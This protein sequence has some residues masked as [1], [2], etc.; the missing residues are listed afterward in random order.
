M[1]APW[2]ITP[3]WVNYLNFK[4]VECYH[5]VRFEKE[6]RY[7]TIRLERDLLGDWTLC[8]T[9]GRIKAPMAHRRTMSATCRVSWYTKALYFNFFLYAPYPEKASTQR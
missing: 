6:T 4:L 3:P 8:V 5:T 2:F 1:T 9:N 7:Y